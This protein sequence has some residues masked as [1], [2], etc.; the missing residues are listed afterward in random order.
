MCNY[1]RRIG[2]TVMRSAPVLLVITLAFGFSPGAVAENNQSKGPPPVF[3]IYPISFSSG[4]MTFAIQA[5]VFSVEGITAK[6]DDPASK[7]KKEVRFRLSGDVLFDFDK[8]DIRPEAEV[9]LADLAR[10]IRKDFAGAPVRVE[11]HTDAKGA[12]SYN[13]T[14]SQQRAESVKRWFAGPGGISS[15]KIQPQGFGE[16]QPVAPNANPDGTDN[17]QGRQQNRRVEIVVER[18]G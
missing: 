15:G 18:R 13:Q 7:A 10:K 17:P 14:L 8:A 4:P 12:D 6:L 3:D 1:Q 11:G 9:I 5:V 16:K 2:Q